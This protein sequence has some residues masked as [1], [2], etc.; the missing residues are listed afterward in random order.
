[1]LQEPHLHHPRGKFESELTATSPRTTLG[2]TA[3]QG[4][5]EPPGPRTH[6][7]RAEA[8]AVSTPM[9]KAP[10]KKSTSKC[11]LSLNGGATRSLRWN[12]MPAPIANGCPFG[13]AATGPPLICDGS[14][15]LNKS[16]VCGILEPMR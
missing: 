16:A 4:V 7:T 12:T 2:G 9:V 1:M 6:H 15:K 5:G 8:N 3:Y 13:K 11:W 10:F 14:S